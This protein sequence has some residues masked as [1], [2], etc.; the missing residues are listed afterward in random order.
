MK[1]VLMLLMAMVLFVGCSK[2]KEPIEKTTYT[3]FP[4]GSFVWDVKELGEDMGYRDV[5]VDVL[6]AEYF[7]GQRVAT[8]LFKDV[9][10]GGRYT[11]EAHEKTEYVTVRIDCNNLDHP[12]QKDYIYKRFIA[13]VIYLKR[14]QD[15]FI[16]FDESTIVTETE[17]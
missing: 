13:H 6:V 12:K 9:E 14:N 5:S 1:R 3:I 11:N 17:P 4:G 2:D 16:S 7:Q 8:K 10:L 15:T